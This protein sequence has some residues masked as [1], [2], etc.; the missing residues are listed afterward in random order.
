MTVYVYDGSFEGLLTVI[1]EV[2]YNKDKPEVVFKKEEYVHNFL[3]NVIEIFSDENKWKKVYEAIKIKISGAVLRNIY[4]LHLSE[5]KNIER[6]II[7]YT[8]LAFKIGKDVDLHMYN[9]MIFEVHK[10]IKKVEYEKHRVV[11]FVR[12]ASIGESLF[13]SKIEPDHNI[14][15]LIM[16]HFSQRFKEENFII[17]DIK[18]KIGGI[19]SKEKGKWHIHTLYLEDI[20]QINNDELY[21]KLWKE[22]FTSVSIK[23]RKNHRLQKR[24]MP[25]R[26]W[27]HM[28]E[29]NS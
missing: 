26:Y 10:V 11:G 27:K 23:E 2:Y 5:L 20:P 18:R 25:K 9:A 6:L 15:E 12:F 7:E 14:L 4:L 28:S 1:Y 3:H 13:Y 8:K 22:Y 21:N 17:H 29:F 24:M 19:Y 16:P